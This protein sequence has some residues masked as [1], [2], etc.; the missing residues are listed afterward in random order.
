MENFLIA[1]KASSSVF[2]FQS[3][4]ENDEGIINFIM[5]SNLRVMIY[6]EITVNTIERMKN[7][8]PTPN[9]YSIIANTDEMEKIFRK[10]SKMEI[11]FR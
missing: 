8:R 11:T 2:I 10:V 7:L 3:K 4:R 6:E 9:F 1:K 5:Q